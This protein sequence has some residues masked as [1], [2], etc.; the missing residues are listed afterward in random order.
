MKSLY[1]V[2]CWM[3]VLLLPCIASSC[4]DDDAAGSSAA[5]AIEDFSPKEGP[6]GTAVTIT[7]L[8]FGANREDVDG[9]VFFNGIEAA[10][11]LSYSD[12][13]IVAV[14]PYGAVTGAIMVRKG[15]QRARTTENFT[16]KDDSATGDDYPT[17]TFAKTFLCAD[18]V[19][20]SGKCKPC[21]YSD[22]AGSVNISEIDIE[23]ENEIHWIVEGAT[24]LTHAIWDSV[25]GD[26]AIY[27]VT[28]EEAARYYIGFNTAT[29]RDGSEIRVDISQN[30]DE[31]KEGAVTDLSYMKAITN[32]GSFG[33]F[34][35]LYEYGSYLLEEPGTYYVRLM[36]TNA[37]DATASVCM[38]FVEMY[39]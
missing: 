23:T 1:K 38:K 10:E 5:V 11:Y 27:E 33:D 24:P 4:D 29:N 30:L 21:D 32:N 19:Y 3:T 20:R 37:S 14:V 8:N 2:L 35:N 39:N 17:G 13:E 15:D 7:G 12:N 28:V 25:N 16:Y 22:E 31:L 9:H 26:M 36:L 6:F 18:V 34:S